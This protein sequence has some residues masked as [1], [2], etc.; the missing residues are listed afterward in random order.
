[1]YRFTRKSQS[2]LSFGC[3]FRI[4]ANTDQPGRPPEDRI[5]LSLQT[6]NA[7]LR[8]AIDTHGEL[9]AA[10]AKAAAL[11]E[12]LR[13]AVSACE[14]KLSAYEAVLAAHDPQRTDQ[15]YVL[16]YLHPDNL[17]IERNDFT[18]E[19][20]RAAAKHG[21]DGWKDCCTQWRLSCAIPPDSSG[22]VEIPETMTS[23]A[24][25]R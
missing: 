21:G 4:L 17:G 14:A 23:I 15:L 16:L 8:A 22:H 10:E 3:V 18:V 7:D 11:Q 19:E 5:H 12:E 25:V 6:E 20:A 2:L 1:M 24:Y 9:I 13:A